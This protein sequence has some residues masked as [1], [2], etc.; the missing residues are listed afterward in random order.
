MASLTGCIIIGPDGKKYE[1]SLART[2]NT[3]STFDGLTEIELGLKIAQL[4][5]EKHLT[6]RQLAIIANMT[7]AQICRIEKGQVKKPHQ[8]SLLAIQNALCI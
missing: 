6:Q 8:V 3:P 7:Q 2:E 1:L 4:R 5:I